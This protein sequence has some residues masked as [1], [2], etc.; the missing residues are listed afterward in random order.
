[1]HLSVQAARF[2]QYHGAHGDA[3]DAGISAKVAAEQAEQAMNC[4]LAA[5]AAL[6]AHTLSARL[7]N[8][9]PLDLLDTQNARHLLDL[10]HEALP[11]AEAVDKERGHLVDAEMAAQLLPVDTP[12]MDLAEAVNRLI[13]RLSTEI[14]G[15][16]TGRE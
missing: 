6:D 1:L 7:D 15:P 9:I 5:G 11:V 12:G 8:A 16:Q 13:L 10:L 3:D 14:H 2:A 4:L